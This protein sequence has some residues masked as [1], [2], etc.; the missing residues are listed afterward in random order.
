MYITFTIDN[1]LTFIILQIILPK[2][3]SEEINTIFKFVYCHSF[4]KIIGS[5]KLFLM[6]T[7]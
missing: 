4:S 1:K 5:N 2:P 3:L 7:R 6:N